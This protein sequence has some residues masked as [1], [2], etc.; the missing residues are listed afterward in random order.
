[1]SLVKQNFCLAEE[2]LQVF[3]RERKKMGLNKSAY[4]R[5]L[6]RHAGG[7]VPYFIHY[8]DLLQ[9]VSELNSSVKELLAKDMMTDAEKLAVQT[10]LGDILRLVSDI[11]KE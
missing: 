8:R 2:D 5:Y 1:M 3:E 11:A 10:E 4:M 6:I 7:N 9:Q